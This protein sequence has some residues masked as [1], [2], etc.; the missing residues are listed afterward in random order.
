MSIREWNDKLV[1]N[2]VAEISEKA[3]LESGKLVAKDMKSTTAFKDKTGKLRKSINSF[4]SR[5]KDGGV[6]A[7]AFAPHAHLIEAGTK[8]RVTKT[9][10]S[11]GLLQPR[12]FVRP[13]L[14]KNK[15]KILTIFKRSI[16]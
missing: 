5:Y 12:P 8:K 10:R 13:A 16:S 1:Y 7:G 6:I 11:T 4:K 9:G 2:K 3:L 14:E 15:T